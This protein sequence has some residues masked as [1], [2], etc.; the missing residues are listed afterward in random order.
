M[1]EG[2]ITSS[3]EE[4]VCRE[5]CSSACPQ[6]A[7][8]LNLCNDPCPLS[9]VLL[10]RGLPNG[11]PAIAYLTGC[12]PHEHA[13]NY[14]NCFWEEEVVDSD[15]APERVLSLSMVSEGHEEE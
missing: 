8:V 6:Y 7:R 14:T 3:P 2:M 4:K 12:E 10:L 13:E 1:S 15:V 5:A 9:L 11:E